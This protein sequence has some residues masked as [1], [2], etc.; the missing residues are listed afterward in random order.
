[1]RWK[2]LTPAAGGIEGNARDLQNVGCA[3]YYGMAFRFN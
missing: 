2:E 1:M 3:Y